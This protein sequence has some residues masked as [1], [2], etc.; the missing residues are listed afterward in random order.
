MIH[1]STAACRSGRSVMRRT[2]VRDVMT[3]RGR[4]RRCRCRGGW[5]Q[6]AAVRVRYPALPIEE[7]VVDGTALY[8]LGE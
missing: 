4:H 5:A 8:A 3:T 7:R 1:R 6:L 2:V